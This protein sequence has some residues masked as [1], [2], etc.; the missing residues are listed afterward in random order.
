[1]ENKYN[2]YFALEGLEEDYFF[3]IVET[4][5]VHECFSIVYEN[6]K[7]YGNIAPHLQ[8]ALSE[9]LFDCLFA[10]YDVDYRQ[11]EEDSPYQSVKN[12]LFEIFGDDDAVEAVSICVN[13]NI[14]QLY[15]L[16][17]DSLS[18]VKLETSSKAANTSIVHKYWPNI[19]NEVSDSAG[20][21]VIKHYNAKQWQVEEIYY[22]YINEQY[23]YEA[24]LRNMSCLSTAYLDN[25]PG[26]NFLP[27]LLA[28]KNG[29]IDFFKDKSKRIKK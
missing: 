11:D 8:I 2:I 6:V 28:L 3:R 15:L 9:E 27:I 12:S 26:S 24:M 21:N 10:V 1:M 14:L 25:F 13:P 18:N 5:G 16:G 20:H 29:D 23:S 4:F 22:S 19:G 17:C 7:G